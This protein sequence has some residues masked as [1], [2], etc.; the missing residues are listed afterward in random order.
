MEQLWKCV[1]AGEELEFLSPKLDT[2]SDDDLMAISV[3]ALSGTEGSKT[4]R[5]RG[6]LQ[7]K[8]VFMLIDSRSSHSFISD[9]LL[10][11]LDVDNS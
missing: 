7:G 3:Q 8:E 4:I 1:T 5:L 11:Y 2:D 10:P 9:Q 6:Y